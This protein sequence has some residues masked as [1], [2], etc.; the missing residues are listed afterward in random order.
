MTGGHMIVDFRGLSA[1]IMAQD[2]AGGKAQPQYV[3]T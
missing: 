3:P 1:P 2:T